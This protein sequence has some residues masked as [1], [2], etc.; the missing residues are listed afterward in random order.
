[1]WANAPV[2]ADASAVAE[3]RHPQEPGE[4]DDPVAGESVKPSEQFYR[5]RLLE[6]FRHTLA[7][8]R[9]RAGLSIDSGVADK[10][11]YRVVIWAALLSAVAHADEDFC[12]AEEDQLLQ[13]L[14]VDKTVPTPDVHLVVRSYREAALDQFDLAWLVREFMKVAAPEEA[15]RLLDCLFLVAAADGELHE[16]ELAVIREI[17]ARLGF[18]ERAFRSARSRCE[19]RMKRGWN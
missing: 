3:D 15:G 6:Y 4:L 12:P 17:V 1:M 2:S 7:L 13:L 16:Q 5:R 9:A 14:Q 10:D 19:V 8:A 11:L 18:P